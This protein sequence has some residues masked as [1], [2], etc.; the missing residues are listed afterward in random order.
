MSVSPS[1]VEEVGRRSYGAGVTSLAPSLR[2]MGLAFLAI[3][4][5]MA[6]SMR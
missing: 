2:Q 3:P 4:P 1:L 5:E 6:P